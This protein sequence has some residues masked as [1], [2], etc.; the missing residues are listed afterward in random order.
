M[1]HKFML[2]F[3]LFIVHQ[4]FAEVIYLSY[5][6]NLVDIDNDG[7]EDLIVKT[8]GETLN[9]HPFDRYLIS[10][11]NEKEMFYEV[12]L[13][14]TFRY[15]FMTHEGAD[16]VLR[17]YLFERDDKGFVVKKFER[18]FGENYADKK[19]VKVTTYRFVN[20]YER[21][22]LLSAG[23]PPCFFNKEESSTTEKAYCDVRALMR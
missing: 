2:I 17:D 11:Q 4:S 9:A 16:C 3:L 20:S 18:A 10:Y 22:D 8:R 21:K 19:P 14:N 12:P 6:A 1:L 7:R 23:M 13:G 5:G 15:E